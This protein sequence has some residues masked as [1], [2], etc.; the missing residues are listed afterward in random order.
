MGLE[1]L[2]Q[3]LFES[4]QGIF[5]MPAKLVWTANK[6]VLLTPISLFSKMLKILG[7]G[8]FVERTIRYKI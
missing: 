1:M 2:C 8:S 7:F 4:S 5:E 3:F 6:Q